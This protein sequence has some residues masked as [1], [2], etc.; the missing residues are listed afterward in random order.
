[1][2]GNG[3]H[4]RTRSQ[5]GKKASPKSREP[6]TARGR[7]NK[8]Q[9]IIELSSSFHESTP[10]V[11][12]LTT[13]VQ[14]KHHSNE[15]DQDLRQ[16]IKEVRSEIKEIRFGMNN[17]TNMIATASPVM[18]GHNAVGVPI[19]VNNIGTPR[20]SAVSE[21]NDT[22]TI[23]A[24][25]GSSSEQQTNSQP[26][27]DDKVEQGKGNGNQEFY[28]GR[29]L[30]SNVNDGNTSTYFI[31]NQ[32]LNTHRYDGR[33]GGVEIPFWY[34]V[35]Y[36]VPTDM[37]L[38]ELEASVAAYIFW[39]NNEDLDHGNEELINSSWGIGKRHTLSCLMLGGRVNSEVLNHLVTKLTTIQDNLS[40]YFSAWF[41]PTTF[42]HSVLDCGATAR[43]MRTFYRKG[44]YI[45]KG[46]RLRKDLTIN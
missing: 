11:V 17:L 25:L 41:F 20:K 19:I 5:K 23:M 9:E 4:M 21:K 16:E 6:K 8:I 32:P 42:A 33:T 12:E 37:I 36:R 44:G 1:M 40:S 30:F 3:L 13:P 18:V 15:D 45:G 34:P 43:A 27:M 31:N 7:K 24:K 14:S 35:N 28:L 46:D 29:R 39:V 38:D 2:A 26:Y 22:D 10:K